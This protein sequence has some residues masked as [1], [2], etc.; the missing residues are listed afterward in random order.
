MKCQIKIIVWQ[1]DVA[2]FWTDPIWESEPFYA[3]SPHSAKREATNIIKGHLFEMPDNKVEEIEALCKR[4][5]RGESEK[6]SSK[7]HKD[8][9]IVIQLHVLDFGTLDGLP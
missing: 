8:T 3:T 9:R 5:W 1:S 7:S 2:Y 6:L 4:Q